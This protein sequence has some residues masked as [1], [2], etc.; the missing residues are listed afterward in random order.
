MT[1]F[2]FNCEGTTMSGVE[3]E[4]VG[5]GYRVSLVKRRFVSGK[6]RHS[7]S[8]PVHIDSFRQLCVSISRNAFNF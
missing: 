4:L 2:Q 6:A 8:S 1:I 3:F 7:I 5:V